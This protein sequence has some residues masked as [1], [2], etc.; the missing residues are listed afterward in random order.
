VPD[1]IGGQSSS[2]NDFV[3]SLPDNQCRYAGASRSSAIL[4]IIHSQAVGTLNEQRNTTACCCHTL[5]VSV[6]CMLLLHGD[7][8]FA[9]CD[10][11]HALC[12]AAPNPQCMLRK[13]WQHAC[14]CVHDVVCPP[15]HDS[16]ACSMSCSLPLAV[17]DYE[18][19]SPER[20]A[21]KKMVFLLWWVL[22]AALCAH[23]AG[24]QHSSPAA[25]N[26]QLNCI[27]AKA[28]LLLLQQERHPALG[29]AVCCC[30]HAGMYHIT[31]L[32]V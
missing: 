31:L 19:K 16:P 20:G 15:A 4:F 26:S 18:Y 13:C 23:L 2:Y 5:H 12:H 8:M 7:V 30:Q 10:S 21:F 28:T 6:A 29:G 22:P 11:R 25:P 17:Y 14:V 32:P 1:K 3:C 27:V 9:V 24:Q